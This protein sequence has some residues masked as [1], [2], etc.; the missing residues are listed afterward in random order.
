MAGVGGRARTVRVMECRLT[1]FLHDNWKTQRGPSNRQGPEAR[2]TRIPVAI[3]ATLCVPYDPKYHKELERSAALPAL[4]TFI[5][6]IPSPYGLGSRLAVGPPGLSELEGPALALPLSRTLTGWAH[7]WRSALRALAN[8]RD[9]HLL[10]HSHGPLR[11][12]LTFGGR[13]PGLSELEGPALSLLLARTLTGWAQVWRS[14]PG[15][16]ASDQGTQMQ[17]R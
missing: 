4:R 3:G 2:P 7:V 17:A 11:V 1:G 13:P 9:P 10:F 14:A 15:L 6:S 8:W 16:E 12:G 5:E